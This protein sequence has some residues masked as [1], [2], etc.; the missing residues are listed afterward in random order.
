[1]LC[2]AV[3]KVCDRC[4]DTL[5]PF[6]NVLFIFIGRSVQQ[7]NPVLAGF[8]AERAWCEVRFQVSRSVT[9]CFSLEFAKSL[10]LLFVIREL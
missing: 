9:R 8:A 7:N 3:V 6:I 1:M 5:F 10:L 4:S 2:V